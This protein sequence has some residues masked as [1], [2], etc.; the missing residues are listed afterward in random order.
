MR[1]IFSLGQR[2][3][4]GSL[5]KIE[6]LLYQKIKLTYRFVVINVVNADYKIVGMSRKLLSLNL[7]QQNEDPYYVG[8][9]GD[10][11]GS[12]KR[13]R[14]KRRAPVHIGHDVGG[15]SASNEPQLV[16]SMSCPPILNRTYLCPCRLCASTVGMPPYLTLQELENHLSEHGMAPTQLVCDF[17]PCDVII[18]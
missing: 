12:S 3:F 4:V 6:V 5:Y 15:T 7:E 1:F 13:H 10:E 17:K 2:I 9:P 14:R 11:V 16:E 8:V 18:D